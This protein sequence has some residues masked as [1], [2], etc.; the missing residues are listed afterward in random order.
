MDPR[1]GNGNGKEVTGIVGGSRFSLLLAIILAGYIYADV[2]HR[3]RVSTLPPTAVIFD[4][5]ILE[6]HGSRS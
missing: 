4:E 6:Y 3:I 5:R 1:N 2:Y